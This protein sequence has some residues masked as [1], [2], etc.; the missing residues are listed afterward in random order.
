MLRLAAPVLLMALAG[1]FTDT[2][3]VKVKA[4]GSGTVEKVS[5]MSAEKAADLAKRWG[6]DAPTPQQFFSVE[7]AK[8]AAANMGEGVTFVSAEPIKTPKEEGLK[9]VYA[10]TDVTKLKLDFSPEV[11]KGVSE[12][13]LIHF[14]LVKLPN[15]NTLVTAVFGDG[16][17]GEPAAEIKEASR[18]PD[19]LLKE[20]LGGMKFSVVVEPQGT[21]VKTESPY[22]E[23]GKVTLWE[24]DM[25]PGL[26]DGVLLKKFETLREHGKTFGQ[27]RAIF[28]DVPGLKLPRAD[29]VTI[30]FTGK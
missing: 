10:F 28:K 2:T 30:E 7:K 9:A 16:E 19:P 20:M 15:G 6:K 22:S 12:E 26:K 4:D 29:E 25:D 1:C 21:V 3:T 8:A 24:W 14:K 13:R 17:K 5:L 27:V 18:E 23:A 11:R